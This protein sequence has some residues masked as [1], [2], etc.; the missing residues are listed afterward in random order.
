MQLKLNNSEIYV[1]AI[2]T[3]AENHGDEHVPAADLAFETTVDHKMVDQ[4]VVGPGDDKLS[5]LLWN[6][7]QIRFP[8]LEPIKVERPIENLR[9]EVIETLEKN[10]KKKPMKF[11]EVKLKGITFAPQQGGTAILSGKIQFNPTNG[12]WDRVVKWMKENVFLSLEGQQRDIFEE[13]EDDDEN[14]AA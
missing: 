6:G 11:T 4:I 5:A 12:Q 3:R 9:M 2:N 8:G 10:A 1:S 14:Q 13:G 7:K